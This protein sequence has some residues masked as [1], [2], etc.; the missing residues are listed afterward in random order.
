MYMNDEEFLEYVLLHSQTERHAFNLNDYERLAELADVEEVTIDDPGLG[1]RFVG[2][3]HGEALR[4]VQL[5]RANLR[6]KKFPKKAKPDP[7]TVL[8][9]RMA[10][11]EAGMYQGKYKTLLLEHTESHHR[12]CKCIWCRERK[13]LMPGVRRIK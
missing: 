13:K 10:Q 11:V 8:T 9:T 3:R 4:L 5:A 6:R 7:L 12:T 1:G 2:I